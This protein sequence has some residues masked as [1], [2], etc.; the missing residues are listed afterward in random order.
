VTHLHEYQCGA[1]R[2][3]PERIKTY[4]ES[5]IIPSFY[6]QK[7]YNRIWCDIPSYSVP[8]LWSPRV[9]EHRSRSLEGIKA[10]KLIWKYKSETQK[11]VICSLDAN[12][13]ISKTSVV[14][15]IAGEYIYMR[16]PLLVKHCF[17]ANRPNNSYADEYI[18]QLT[19]PVVSN[20][21]YKEIDQ[22]ICELNNDDS[23]P[24]LV[25][26]QMHHSLNYL[27]YEVMYYG[28]PF[29]HNSPF[30]KHLGYYYEGDDIEACA[31][32][33]M[34]AH[35]THPRQWETMREA[36]MKYLQKIDP[37]DEDVQEYHKQLL[38]A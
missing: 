11:M 4:D 17:L 15:L 36:N 38:K 34:T 31:T 14:A 21:G 25:F 1:T 30:L 28:F 13:L 32:A 37:Y 24:I 5:W 27:Y 23:F 10:D 2:A 29:V 26:H 18:H 12:Q 33:I 19:I 35:R 22:M 8:H 3:G 7:E 16:H 6:E 20:K 9:L